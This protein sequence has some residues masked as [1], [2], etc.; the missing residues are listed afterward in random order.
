MP[1]WLRLGPPCV[2]VTDAAAKL[3]AD[4]RPFVLDVRNPDEFAAGHIEGATL[5]PLHE[6]TAKLGGLPRDREVICVCASGS[7]SRRAAKILG[8]EGVYALDLRGGMGAWARAGLPIA[9]G[10]GRGGGRDTG[11][12]KP[13]RR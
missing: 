2:T 7:R 9:R 10:G 11:R 8:R 13:K 5:I 12:K 4:P 3:G 1:A 6:L